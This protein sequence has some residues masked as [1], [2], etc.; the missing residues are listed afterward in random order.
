MEEASRE[1]ARYEYERG[2]SRKILNG[3]VTLV[4]SLDVCTNDPVDSFE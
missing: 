4:A 2:G 3:V 1:R